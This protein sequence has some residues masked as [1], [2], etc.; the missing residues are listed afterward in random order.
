VVSKSR[1][2]G[3]GTGHQP[4]VRFAASVICD[5]ERRDGRD[6]DDWLKAE[7]EVTGSVD[8]QWAIAGRCKGV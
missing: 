7:S 4:L 6:F 3:A 5:R 8:R 1:S 2:P